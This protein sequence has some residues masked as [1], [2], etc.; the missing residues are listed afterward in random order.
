MEVKGANSTAQFTPVVTLEKVDTDAINKD[1][2]EVYK[3]RCAL[4]RFVPEKGSEPAS[5]KQ[6]GKGDVKIVEDTKTGTMMMV[7]YQEKTFRLCLHCAIHPDV[8]LT[9]NEGSDRSWVWRT[10]DYANLESPGTPIDE[11][12]AIMFRNSDFAD[13]FKVEYEKWGKKNKKVQTTSGTEEEAK[14]GE[15]QEET[16]AETTEETKTEEAKE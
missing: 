5:W 8:E 13:A 2:K 9:A 14:K 4:Y 12:F 3:Q 6:R 15:T 1:L 10:T 16:K 7:M 11:T